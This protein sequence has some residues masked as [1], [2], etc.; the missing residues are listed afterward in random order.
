[1]SH[2][3]IYGIYSLRGVF[4][5]FLL[6]SIV[7]WRVRPSQLVGKCDS[8]CCLMT[9]RNVLSESTV[10]RL[11]T[12]SVCGLCVGEWS[13]V[14]R[15][16]LDEHLVEQVFVVSPRGG[17]E[18]PTERCEA[19]LNLYKVRSD[20]YRTSWFVLHPWRWTNWSQ[21]SIDRTKT[22]TTFCVLYLSDLWNGMK[23]AVNFHVRSNKTDKNKMQRCQPACFFWAT[24]FFFWAT[25]N[26]R[27]CVRVHTPA[28]S[29]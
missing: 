29:A 11:K 16:Q 28:R 14:R 12:I 2:V 6:Y 3:T 24:T 27:R 17:N 13:W 26:Q 9:H 25:T 22:M 10:G 7:I 1:M 5:S 15:S 19:N 20:L 18:G 21:D 23:F 4:Y 8:V